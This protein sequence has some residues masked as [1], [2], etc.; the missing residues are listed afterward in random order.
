MITKLALKNFKGVKEGCLEFAPLTI[1]LGANNSGKTTVLEALFLAPN[2]LRTIPYAAGPAGPRMHAV[3]LLEAVHKTLES[4]GSAFL[5]NNYMARWAYV[6]ADIDG[7]ASSIA[8]VARRDAQRI[9]VIASERALDPQVL[10][11]AYAGPTSLAVVSSTPPRTVVKVG[12]KIVGWRMGELSMYSADHILDFTSLL[13]SFTREALLF[14]PDLIELAWNYARQVWSRV[15]GERIGRKVA[16]SISELI[17]ERYL[18]LMIEDF[19]GGRRAVYAYLEDGSAI[20]LGDLG[21]GVQVLTTVM[22]MTELSKPSVVLWDDVESHMNPRALVWTADWLSDLIQGG[23]QAVV[24][25]HSLEATRLLAQ[26]CEDAGIK[27]SILLLRLEDGNLRSK[28]LSL[29]DL[30]KSLEAGVDVRLADVL[31]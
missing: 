1:L 5:L 13:R 22:L 14:R 3:S 18:D 27:H 30:E 4:E 21:D 24:S 2:P 12:D 10:D 29:R 8:F 16:G 26:R 25:T 28:A 17:A 23:T 20:R 31:L 11:D 19:G 15:R 9:H 6:T 7:R